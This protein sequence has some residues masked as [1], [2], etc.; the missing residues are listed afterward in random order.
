MPKPP[1]SHQ[2]ET[3]P[4]PPADGPARHSK[5]RRPLTWKDWT[6]I[7]TTCAALLAA[8]TPLA[9]HYLPKPE[10]AATQHVPRS[11]GETSSAPTTPLP[12][13]AS[14]T[15]LT[16]LVIDTTA[17]ELPAGDAPYDDFSTI[18]TT[19]STMSVPTVWDDRGTAVW[20]QRDGTPLG[21]I[22]AASESLKD[23]SDR[24]DVP[25][26]QLAT[27]GEFPDLHTLAEDKALERAACTGGGEPRAF[28]G[29]GYVGEFRIWS[30]CGN[31]P[32][33]RSIT[34]DLVMQD[35]QFLGVIMI[36]ARITDANAAG[37]FREAL[38]SLD[39]VGPEAS[40]EVL[41]ERIAD[42]EPRSS[43]DMRVSNNPF[44]IPAIPGGPDD[45]LEMDDGEG[46]DDT[47][48]TPTPTPSP[49]PTPTTH[50]EPGSGD[51]QV[52]P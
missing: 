24:W 15:E 4:V 20:A 40:A 6:V 21:E 22:V 47:T 12:A 3:P 32:E 43:V 16:D 17:A 42:G 11:S 36:F 33:Q 7:A 25:G 23:L 41:A 31:D 39:T 18:N 46:P 50:K 29:E 37:A 26:V 30:R 49:A 14:F 28:A 38:F 35:K 48:D 45:L 13:V 52:A 44:D 2:L 27:S 1:E 51:D 8:I 34:V 10:P 19:S 9:I 5:T